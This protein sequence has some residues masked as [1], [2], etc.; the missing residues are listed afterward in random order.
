M[1][2]SAKTAG[3]KWF[4][5][6]IHIPALP[7]TR[8]NP[9][10]SREQA[11]ARLAALTVLD[12]GLA[13]ATHTQLFEPVGPASAT[14]ILWHGFTNAPSQFSQAGRALAE[15]GFRVL[16]PR[17]PR[18]GL[19]DVLT[20]DLANLTVAELT[21]HVDACID[22]TA[23]FG[24]PVWVLGLSGGAALA[25]WA[26]ATRTEVQRLVLAAPLVAPKG[27]PL[28]LVRLFVR[29]PAIVPKFYFWWDPRKKAELGNSPYAYPGFPVPGIIPFLHLTEALFDRSAPATHRLEWTALTS[30]PG[31]LAI[32]LDAARTF[33]S[34]IFFPISQHHGVANIDRNLKWMHDFVDPYTPG[35]ASTEQL[36]AILLAAFGE[37]EPTAAGVLV[38]PLVS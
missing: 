29:F 2:A 32:R 15:R 21:T 38:P 19:P 14:V 35:A 10:T 22:I 12:S 37:G 6:A 33:V 27:F 25:A 7:P 36:V 26:G 8:A 13:E 23:G 11:L 30:N 4:R 1:D 3:R 18:H 17:M 16:V 20:R 9:T 5:R 31:D 34:Q 24:D 28:P